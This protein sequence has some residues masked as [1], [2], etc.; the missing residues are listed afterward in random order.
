M[1]FAS[2]ISASL[3]VLLIAT[4]FAPKSILVAQQAPPSSTAQTGG[5]EQPAPPNGTPDGN[6]GRGNA[7]ARPVLR[8]RRRQ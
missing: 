7:G 4:S 3:A 8:L 5:P 6:R 2:L 1:K